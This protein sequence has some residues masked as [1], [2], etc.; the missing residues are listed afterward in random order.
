MHSCSL[1]GW[2]G[3]G[4]T[5]VSFSISN[6]VVLANRHFI[7]R[8]LVALML[9]VSLISRLVACSAR[10]SVDRHTDQVQ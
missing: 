8:A 3:H 9:L 2:P 4:A 5:R 1:I 6:A 10:I 7:F